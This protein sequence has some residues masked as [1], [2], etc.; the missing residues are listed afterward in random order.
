MTDIGRRTLVK[1]LM[2]FPLVAAVVE[3]FPGTAQATEVHDVPLS[4][5]ERRKLQ[6][7]SLARMLNTAQIRH[8]RAFGH[9][10]ALADLAG[11]A[12][13]AK[14]LDS[15]KAKSKGT[16]REL[17][18]KLNTKTGDFAREWRCEFRITPDRKRYSILIVDQTMDRLPAIATDELGIIH[19]GRVV[20]HQPTGEILPAREI[21]QGEPIGTRPRPRGKVSSFLQSLSAFLVVPVHADHCSGGNDCC[22]NFSCCHTE[23]CACVGSCQ[24]TH[25][26]P[27]GELEIECDNCG[28][29]CCVWCC[30]T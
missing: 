13:V 14:Y 20:P 12:A 6:G 16:G 8:Q 3:W 2:A 1:R 15:E 19:M 23:P 28:C 10:V 21:V 5:I 27:G 18:L 17:F 29:P 24:S 7:L 25:P 22:C 26:D 30:G 9:Y 11:S 4:R